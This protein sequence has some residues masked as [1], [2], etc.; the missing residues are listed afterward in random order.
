MRDTRDPLYVPWRTGL[1]ADIDPRRGDIE[2]DASSTKRRSLLSLAGSLLAEI[3]IPKLLTAWLL[4]IV[5]PGLLLGVA[6]IVAS[7][8]LASCPSK[9]AYVADGSLAASCCSSLVAALGWFGGRRVPGGES[10]ASG[11]SIRWPFSRAMRLCREALRHLA[12]HFLRPRRRARS[13][14]PGCGAAAGAG[15]SACRSARRAG[16]A[17]LAGRALDLSAVARLGRTAAGWR[18][19]RWPTAWCCSAAIWRSASLVWAVRRRHRWISRATLTSFDQP[20]R[21]GRILA[22][23]SPVGPPC[24][25][26]ALRLPHRERPVGPARQRTAGAVLA[27]L[28]AH[29]RGAAHSTRSSL[30]ATSPMPDGR[31]N[32]PSFSTPLAPHPELAS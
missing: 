1:R 19:R 25:R 26:R 3:S 28:D 12:E 29:S 2:D 18:G 6:P 27:Q 21:N 8:W 13:H 16:G 11:R 32:G 31:P 17:V 14:A 20:P 22:G 5:L 23:R 4:L 10:R 24:R 15:L 9:F 7:V 30:P